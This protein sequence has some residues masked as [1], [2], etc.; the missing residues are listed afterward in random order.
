MNVTPNTVN[1]LLS[2]NEQP[3]PNSAFE[4]EPVKAAMDALLPENGGNL[5]DLQAVAELCLDILKSCA[6]DDAAN[7]EDKEWRQIMSETVCNLKI[8]ETFLEKSPFIAMNDEET[9]DA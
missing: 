3:D 1:E 6:E 4:R 7:D 8:A 9:D 2:I 5:G